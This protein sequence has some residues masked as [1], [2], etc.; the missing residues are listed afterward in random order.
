MYCL[1]RRRA[2]KYTNNSSPNRHTRHHPLDRN[3]HIVATPDTL[4]RRYN[5][6]AAPYLI[7][8]KIKL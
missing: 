5:S 4:P 3:P 8:K 2:A 7:V 1:N 6:N